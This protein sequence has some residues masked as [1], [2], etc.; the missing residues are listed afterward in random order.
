MPEIEDDL[1]A[2]NWLSVSTF[3]LSKYAAVGGE[4]LI[5]ET[6]TELVL[7]LPG[8]SLSSEGINKRFRKLAESVRQ[9]GRNEV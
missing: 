6:E 5:E 7:R 1:K 2:K 4:L 3:D 9:D 8:V